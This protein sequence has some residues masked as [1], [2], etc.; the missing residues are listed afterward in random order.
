MNSTSS[1]DC[2]KS[3]CVDRAH[4]TYE[5]LLACAMGLLDNHPPSE[6]TSEMILKSSG[7]SKGSLYYHFNDLSDLLETALVR[8]FS[9]VVDENIAILREL[10]TSASN[11]ADYHRAVIDFNNF[12]QSAERSSFRLARVRL[13]GLATSNTRMA[14]RLAAEQTRLTKVYTELLEIAQAKGWLRS[15]ISAHGIAVFF[16]AIT[17]GRV[18]DDI[19]EELMDL[20]NWKKLIMKVAQDFLLPSFN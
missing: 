6:I 13:L 9:T 8:S 16:Q 4:P 7:V 11:A 1:G 3:A 5:H 20:E 15:D 18:V 12:A 19:S 2:T 17:V 14:S 10:T